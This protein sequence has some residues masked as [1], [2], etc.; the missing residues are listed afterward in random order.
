MV[1]EKRLKH[2]ILKWILKMFQHKNIMIHTNMPRNCMIF[3]G[4]RY[5]TRTI[6]WSQVFDSIKWPTVLVRNGKP[7]IFE[8]CLC[9][10]LYSTS[11]TNS[12]NPRQRVPRQSS[13]WLVSCLQQLILFSQ[14]WGIQVFFFGNTKMLNLFW[15]Y[16]LCLGETSFAQ[17]LI[18]A[19]RCCLPD[20]RDDI[21]DKKFE[22]WI[23]NVAGTS[24]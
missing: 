6:L 24:S 4:R 9:W 20:P 16:L 2:I 15:S 13:F 21:S 23:F 17:Q 14:C 19:G 3:L 7:C 11:L 5:L 8:A 18:E 1:Y 10:W 22:N 12:T